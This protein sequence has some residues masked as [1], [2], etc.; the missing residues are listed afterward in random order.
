MQRL[1]WSPFVLQGRDAGGAR[2][3]LVGAVEHAGS[4]AGGHYTSFSARDPAWRPPACAGSPAS[5]VPSSKAP[6]CCC[7]AFEQGI[8]C[9]RS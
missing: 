7:R 3:V 9:G 2:Y 4:M 8:C 5:S 1:S 6:R